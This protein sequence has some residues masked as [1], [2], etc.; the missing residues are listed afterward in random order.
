MEKYKNDVK[1]LRENILKMTEDRD[2]RYHITSE[3]EWFRFLKHAISICKI[4]R[5]DSKFLDVGCGSGYFAAMIKIIRP[6]IDLYASDITPQPEWNFLAKKYG[7]SFIKEDAL[8]MAWKDKT[9]DTVFSSGLIEHVDD[10]KLLQ[11]INRILKDGGINFIFNMKNINSITENTCKFFKLSKTYAYHINRYDRKK[12]YGIMK[13]NG[14]KIKAIKTEGFIPAQYGLFG[15]KI[16][17]MGN[18]LY[19]LLYYLD[20]LLNIRSNR[21]SQSFLITS[22]KET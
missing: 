18:K 20:R 8:K 22:I 5:K 2:Q 13:R 1:E 19:K 4:V 9:F 12:I 6:D 3:L 15:E 14:F 7:I 21:Y 17:W 10:D 11:E 16:E